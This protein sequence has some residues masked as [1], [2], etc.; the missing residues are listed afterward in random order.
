MLKFIFFTVLLM[1]AAGACA[2]VLILVLSQVLGE[3]LTY[4]ARYYL[5]AAAVAVMLVPVM[6]LN[7]LSEHE[8][9]P[10]Q[11]SAVQQE[12]TA[13]AEP[14]GDNGALPAQITE[15]TEAQTAANSNKLDAAVERDAELPSTNYENKRLEELFREFESS[16]F[17]IR[18]SKKELYIAVLGVLWIF[19][20][21]VMAARY[22]IG[23]AW[24][25]VKIFCF[26][27]PASREKQELLG[28]LRGRFKIRRKIRLRVFMGD[29]S[30][31]ITGI[32]AN[33]V[34]I[35]AAAEEETLR[36]VLRHE[37]THCKRL[38]LL[39]KGLMELAVILH[40]FNPFVYIL[41]G[42][43]NKYCELSC[44]ELTVEDMDFEDR[45]RYTMAI[46]TMIKKSR[47][48]LHGA[49]ALGEKKS[50]LRERVEFIMKDRKYS[51]GTRLLSRALTAAVFAAS[52]LF[53]GISQANNSAE[54]PKAAYAS[55]NGYS[56]FGCQVRGDDQIITWLNLY[57]TDESGVFTDFPGY[58]R[59]YACFMA[60]PVSKITEGREFLEKNGQ[61]A[62]WE[63]EDK[64]H[65]EPSVTD[66]YEITLKSVEKRMNYLSQTIE[67]RAEV[68]RNGS[69]I[70]DNQAIYISNVPGSSEYKYI[71]HSTDIELPGLNVDGEVVDLS[72]TLRFEDIT[73]DD[74]IKFESV[75][76][77]F[78]RSRSTKEVYLSELTEAKVN[79][80]DY[81]GWSTDENGAQRGTE[82]L[83]NEKSQNANADFSLYDADRNSAYFLHLSPHRRANVTGSTV[84][85][86]FLV[87]VNDAQTRNYMDL[88]KEVKSFTISGLDGAEGDFVEV[89]SDDGSI[90][91]K[92]RIGTKPKEKTRLKGTREV[93]E[94]IVEGED[95]FVGTP[96]EQKDFDRDEHDRLYKRIVVD[97]E[98]KVIFVIPIENQMPD[99][100][101]AAEDKLNDKIYD[102]GYVQTESYEGMAERIL[103]D[104]NMQ[105]AVKIDSLSWWA[106]AIL[107]R[108]NC[109]AQK[110]DPMDAD[111]IFAE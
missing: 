92:C 51:K 53:G 26:S 16:A 80:V 70:A 52:V 102:D 111:V 56:N 105:A 85:A 74:R 65:T 40:F 63:R 110:R 28:E 43:V 76:Y 73:P 35:P 69:V 6:P 30:P 42:Y 68:K 33:T 14:Q 44:D 17:P 83:F 48:R 104:E 21:A 93:S 27:H 58:T 37:L 41:K 77:N 100:L 34:Y 91:A 94:F 82:F 45:K 5:G 96:A 7:G 78:E 60:E 15:N 32:F 99:A 107:T 61:E 38:D 13:N 97:D 46:L 54:P 79:G 90:Y 64:N 71:T 20:A 25:R 67:G 108:D 2:S 19:G 55:D 24:F 11:S 109:F 57:T 86:D 3:R 103:N 81:Y 49:A 4:S 62:Y 12:K 89:R 75:S 84:K 23:A 36:L 47:Y 22:I 18:A 98:G 106:T 8:A 59:L 72:V 31:F 101:H 50:N 95:Y 29:M 88:K 66:F 39:Y 9:L 10:V 87:T 1:S